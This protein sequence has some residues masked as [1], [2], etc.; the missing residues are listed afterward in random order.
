MTEQET[1]VRYSEEASAA[2][3]RCRA[4]VDIRATE[5]RVWSLLTDAADYPRWNS[6]ITR[7]EGRIADGERLVLHAPGTTQTFRPRVSLDRAAGRMSWSNGLPGLFRGERC[8]TIGPAG[9]EG[10]RVVM[11]ESFSGLLFALTRGLL[12]D[13][14]P[15]FEA[16]LGGLKSAAE[17]P[18]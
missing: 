6:T 3:L 8:F 17:T 9:S 12:P 2:T 15:I 4:E 1:A 18:V 13:F 5:D 7:V 14:R 10:L 16:F 11:E